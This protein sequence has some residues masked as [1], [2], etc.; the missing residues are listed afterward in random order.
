[1]GNVNPLTRRTSDPDYNDN[2]AQLEYVFDITTAD[3]EK[4]R[5]LA[6]LQA[7]SILEVLEW[8]SRQPS[9]PSS[10]G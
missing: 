2:V 4:G 10:G 9:A 7:H 1:M 5:L 8:F 3:G 6:Q